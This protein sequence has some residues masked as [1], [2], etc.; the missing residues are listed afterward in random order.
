MN[1]LRKHVGVL[2]T[3][4]I[5]VAGWV[6][7]LSQAQARNDGTAE[8]VREIELRGSSFARETRLLVDGQKE[9]IVEIKD[10]LK[11][12]Q[13]QVSELAGDVKATRAAVESRRTAFSTQFLTNAVAL[14]FQ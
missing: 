2:V 6:W 8:R 3:I 12:L 14:K 1:F 10:T 7:A 5:T 13:K 4:L 9:D 11:E